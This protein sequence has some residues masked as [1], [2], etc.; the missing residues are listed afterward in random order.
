MDALVPDAVLAYVQPQGGW[1]VCNAGV[2]IGEATVITHEQTR[3]AM[4]RDGC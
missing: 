4:R 3:A 2:L 1:C